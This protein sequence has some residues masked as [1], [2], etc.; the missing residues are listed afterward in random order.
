MLQKG[1]AGLVCPTCH[2]VQGELESSKFR[3]G[4]GGASKCSVNQRVPLAWSAPATQ[5]CV[6]I[7]SFGRHGEVFTGKF[8]QAAAQFPPTCSV[9]QVSHVALGPRGTFLVTFISHMS[10]LRHHLEDENTWVPTSKGTSLTPN[11]FWRPVAC[12]LMAFVAAGPS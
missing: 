6:S 11:T 4:T 8:S 10:E 2:Q 3:E 9:T 5:C 1:L 12:S 7:R